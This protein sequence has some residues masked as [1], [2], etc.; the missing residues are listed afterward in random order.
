[1]KSSFGTLSTRLSRR[2]A[3]VAVVGLGEVGLP[4]LVAAGGE[5]FELIGVDADSDNLDSLRAGISYVDGVADSDLGDVSA[6]VLS[7]NFYELSRA[8]IIIVTSPVV[9]DTTESMSFCL[10]DV[11]ASIAEDLQHGQVMVVDTTDMSVSSGD[12][13]ERLADT[14]MADT[15]GVALTFVRMVPSGTW[16][17]ATL[18]KLVT[19]LTV[20][21]AQV[22]AEFYASM[23]NGPTI[24][25]ERP[26]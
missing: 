16:G 13:L 3:T 18:T 6:G 15:A 2:T 10:E 4:L 17:R 14:G 25:T 7:E 23:R 20:E 21:A 22:A 11:A 9:T 8:D 1:M 26:I 19:G 5:G 24:V 12:L